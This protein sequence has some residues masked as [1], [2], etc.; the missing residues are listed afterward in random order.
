MRT[1]HKS[2]KVKELTLTRQPTLGT[3]TAWTWFIPCALALA[4]Y[5][6]S[7]FNGF[8]RDDHVQIVNNPQVQSWEYLPRLLT[9]HLW[10]E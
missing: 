6:P 10:S 9:T 5:M 3:P 1:N 2:K 4:I 8:L 7:L